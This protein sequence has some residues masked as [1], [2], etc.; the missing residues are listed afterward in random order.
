MPVRQPMIFQHSG[1]YYASGMPAANRRVA[2]LGLKRYAEAAEGAF[3]DKRQA[4][5]DGHASHV[6]AFRNAKGT[7]EATFALLKHCEALNGHALT[8]VATPVV[9]DLV[10]GGRLDALAFARQIESLAA[11]D[12]VAMLRKA[13]TDNDALEAQKRAADWDGTAR[14]REASRLL[15]LAHASVEG[16]ATVAH[17]NALMSAFLSCGYAS[18][19]RVHRQVYDALGTHKVQ[20]TARTYALVMQALCLT[21]NTA[22]AESIFNYLRHRHPNA[23]TSEMYGTMIAG[24]TSERDYGKADETW[25]ELMHRGGQPGITADVFELYLKSIFALANTPI[26]AAH[27]QVAPSNINMVE[28]KRIPGLLKE[29]QQLGLSATALSPVTQFKVDEA[30]RTFQI[31]KSRF[32]NWGRSKGQF[33]FLDWRRRH[34]SAQL[35]PEITP[36]VQSARLRQGM[37][38]A[39]TETVSA[40]FDEAPVWEQTPLMHVL[41]DVSVDEANERGRERFTPGV[42]SIHQRSS[43]WMAEVPETRYDKQYG[44]AKPNFAKLG[45]RRALLG[46]AGANAEANKQR[47]KRIVAQT[48]ASA[49]RVRSSVDRLRTHRDE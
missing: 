1:V 4:L 31:F 9:D 35:L 16:G 21:G 19:T 48:L 10:Q 34:N 3:R 23:L 5:V 20:P 39:G 28:L 25:K 47:D 24:W 15:D 14:A 45:V 18:A 43:T 40:K 49:R 38:A 42:E 29:A 17:Y 27:L 12:V 30:L 41:N 26:N 6:A 44:L 2:L 32:Y 13:E 46:D 33:E 11:H 36:T 8:D 22:E 37:N 7:P